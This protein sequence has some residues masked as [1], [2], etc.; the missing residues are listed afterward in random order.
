MQDDQSNYFALPIPTCWY[1]KNLP[2]P[3]RIIVDPMRGPNTKPNASWWN[4]ACIGHIC[5]GIAL[6]MLI[7]CCSFCWPPNANADSDG[8]WELKPIFYWKLSLRWL[9]NANEIDTIRNEMY[10]AITKILRWG[11]NTTY[12]QLTCIGGWHWR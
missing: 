4:I 5:V 1:Q 6:G 12:I 7:S 10:I 3:T 9:P 2:D 11:P 8:I